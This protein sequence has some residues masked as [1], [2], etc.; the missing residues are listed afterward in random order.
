MAGGHPA[1]N[2][3]P[4]QRRRLERVDDDAEGDAD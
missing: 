3:P 4:P 1:N 2:N